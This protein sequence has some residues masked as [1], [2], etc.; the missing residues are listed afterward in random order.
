MLDKSTDTMTNKSLSSVYHKNSFSS[1]L[2]CNIINRSTDFCLSFCLMSFSHR[3]K[4]RDHLFFGEAF[5][6]DIVGIYK[7]IFFFR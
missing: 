3:V 2:N 7:L 4:D 6:K 1:V 5:N